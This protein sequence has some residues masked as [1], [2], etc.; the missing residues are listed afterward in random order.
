MAKALREISSSLSV[1][2]GAVEVADARVPRS[3]R[4]P[5]LDKILGDRPCLLILNKSDLADPALT[6]RWESRYRER[7]VPV[8]AADLRAPKSAGEVRGALFT[9]L[10]ARRERNAA[11][12]MAGKPL[13]VMAVGIPNSGKST[14][15]NRLAGASKARAENR[16]G[17]TRGNTFYR[18]GAGLEILDTPGVL[19]P[20]FAD[21]AEGDRLA[22]TGAVKAELCDPEELA[23]RLAAELSGR[24]SVLLTARYG[25]ALADDPYETLR[26]IAVSRGFTARGGE[27]DTL[28]A[29]AALLEDFR[30]GR[31]GRITLEEPE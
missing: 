17:V 15:I 26:L 16:P 31:L 3:S 4:N 7:G 23:A 19:W 6:R 25:V 30:S 10:S 11:R 2:D 20:R 14:L 5:E 13:R 21:P 24:Y 18:A 27:P 28:R 8:L 9:L 1:C 22:F 12:G 29:A